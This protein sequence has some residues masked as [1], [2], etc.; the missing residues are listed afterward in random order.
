MQQFTD[1]TSITQA[2]FNRFAEAVMLTE[3]NINF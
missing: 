3:A 2:I 1:S